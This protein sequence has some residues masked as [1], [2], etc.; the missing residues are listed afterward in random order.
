MPAAMTNI[1]NAYTGESP[2]ELSQFWRKI[3][4]REHEDED[5]KSSTQ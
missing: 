4:K 1:L 3:K 2:A 5:K